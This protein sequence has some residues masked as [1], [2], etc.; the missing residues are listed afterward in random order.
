VPALLRIAAL[1]VRPSPVAA[2]SRFA[3][4][5]TFA[6]P[7]SAP[8][9]FKLTILSGDRELLTLPAERIEGGGGA[10]MTHSL[11]MEAAAE[12]GEYRVR[13]RLEQ[14][15]EAVERTAALAVTASDP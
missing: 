4:E 13:V 5:A 8:V 11:Q 10:L 2:G 12:P 6:A 7:G 14:G 3:I 1:A 9:T 15:D